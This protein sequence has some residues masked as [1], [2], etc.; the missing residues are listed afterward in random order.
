MNFTFYNQGTISVFNPNKTVYVDGKAMSNLDFHL[1]MVAEAN[2]R[3]VYIV[4][5]RNKEVQ[6]KVAN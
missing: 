2:R 6:P 4:N 3:D 1:S 5:N